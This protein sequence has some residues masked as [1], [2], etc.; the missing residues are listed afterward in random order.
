MVV[1]EDPVAHDRALGEHAEIVEPLDRRHPVPAGD[2]VEFR[3][4]LRRMGVEPQV[5]PDR[6]A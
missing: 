2:L 3:Q 4:G 6:L 1:E 5:A